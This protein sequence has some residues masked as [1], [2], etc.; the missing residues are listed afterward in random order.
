MGFLCIPKQGNP[1]RILKKTLQRTDG[2]AGELKLRGR[3]D[4]KRG[5]DGGNKRMERIMYKSKNDIK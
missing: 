2:W 5:L 3:L 4:K 1:Q